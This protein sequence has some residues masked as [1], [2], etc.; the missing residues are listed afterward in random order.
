M[1]LDVT[2]DRAIIDTCRH[3]IHNK[4]RNFLD[5]GASLNVKTNMYDEVA[6]EV[7]LSLLFTDSHVTNSELRLMG[8]SR[9]AVVF[10]AKQAEA[11][12]RDQMCI[13]D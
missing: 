3:S 1:T 4:I 6:P 2:V 13:I 7:N 5:G 12:I 8:V 9:I 11:Q 10:S